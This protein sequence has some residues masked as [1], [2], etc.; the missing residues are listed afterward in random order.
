MATESPSDTEFDVL[1]AEAYTRYR[2]GLSETMRLELD[3]Y[4][5]LSRDLRLMRV[6]YLGVLDIETG[7]LPTDVPAGDVTD[8]QARGLLYES[9]RRLRV[10]RDGFAV[11]WAWKTEIEPHIRKTPFQGLWR[12]VLGW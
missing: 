8:A 1:T 7:L 2:D 5:R 12:Q 6:L 9:G 10:T 3:L 11:F 4:T